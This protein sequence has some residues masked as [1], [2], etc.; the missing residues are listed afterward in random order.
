MSS[1]NLVILSE[2]LLILFVGIAYLFYQLNKLN[3]QLLHKNDALISN[4]KDEKRNT[5]GLKVKIQEQ[6]KSLVCLQNEINQLTEEIKPREKKLK[7]LD[8]ECYSQQL[9]INTLI[10]EIEQLKGDLST[11]KKSLVSTNKLNR[12]LQLEQV[13]S[14]ANTS[15]DYEEMYFDLKNSIAYNM[16]GGDQVLDALRERL[17]ENG[18]IDEGEKLAELKERYNSLGGMLGNFAESGSNSEINEQEKIIYAENLV[19]S[20]QETLNQAEALSEGGNTD[21]SE[22]ELQVD[23]LVEEL[24][25]VMLMNDKL[26]EDL[27]KTTAQLNVFISKARLFQSQKEQIN[28]HKA[29]QTQMHK[30]FVN[31]SSDYKMMSR[32]FKSLEAK[33]DVLTAQLANASDDPEVLG[34]LEKLREKLEV[35]EDMM[36]RMLVEK[37]MVEQQFLLISE[38]SQ[39]QADSSQ[40]LERLKSEHQLLEQQFLDVLSEL[41]SNRN[42]SSPE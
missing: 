6:K 5:K 30:N 21:V 18:N 22:S 11:T 17:Q 25:Q 3:D 26:R 7:Q 1:S 38:E 4:L 33:N 24:D 12:Q 35:K 31:L 29:T 41:D 39:E 40:A 42:I 27:E 34:K 28:M 15:E 23:K 37:D 9:E 8:A 20:A 14:Q 10:K 32:K 2:I 19:N 16:V 36:D 13:T